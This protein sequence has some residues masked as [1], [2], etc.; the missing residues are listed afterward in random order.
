M[1]KL[2]ELLTGT[3]YCGP[4][5]TYTGKPTSLLDA[6]CREHDINYAKSI[7]AGGTPYIQF[8]YADLRM[9]KRM[10]KEASWRTRGFWLSLA[11]I[12]GK[13]LIQP[14]NLDMT[15]YMQGSEK[16]AG[17]LTYSEWA[18]RNT[19]FVN[20]G[21][22]DYGEESKGYLPPN[23]RRRLSKQ[24]AVMP[25]KFRR[26]R[27]GKRRSRGRGRR[28]RRG[29]GRLTTRKLLAW[30]SPARTIKGLSYQNI[31]SIVNRTLW[32]ELNAVGENLIHGSH[33]RWETVMKAVK[34][35]TSE[36]TFDGP[37]E[38]I[39]EYSATYWTIHN[40]NNFMV[41]LEM[42]EFMPKKDAFG[43]TGTPLEKMIS[44]IGKTDRFVGNV[45]NIRSDIPATHSEPILTGGIFDGLS[46]SPFMYLKHFKEVFG[47]WKKIKTR[48]TII[49]PGGYAFYKQVSKYGRIK[50]ETFS[51]HAA[52][53]YIPGTTRFMIFRAESPFMNSSDVADAAEEMECGHPVFNLSFKVETTDT[54]RD[55]INHTPQLHFIDNA[56]TDQ[57]NNPAYRPPSGTVFTV[58]SSVG[59]LNVAAD[60]A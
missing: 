19:E 54:V 4:L 23:K 26:R 9:L 12:G 34:S 10:Y 31:K 15:Q 46:L 27:R 60:Q 20:L 39:W 41:K 44:G 47:N 58:A 29:K 5:T 18:N 36:G 48:K 8:N 57:A 55:P 1:Q 2:N 11:G 51:G 50:Q 37:Q 25:G 43:D 53:P 28:K 7:S 56:G 40:P 42:H 33:G 38:I 59:A 52:I 35:Q 3:K 17:A 6:I 24:V 14:W 22:I 49:G 16:Y 45:L 32:V 13:A 30:L 21:R